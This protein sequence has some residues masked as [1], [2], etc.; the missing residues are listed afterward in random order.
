MNIQV[1]IPQVDY[2][3]M[4]DCTVAI[5]PGT[6]VLHNPNYMFNVSIHVADKCN[7]NCVACG[8]FSPLVPKDTPDMTPA[9]FFESVKYVIPYR[10]HIGC[11]ILTGGEP[12][13]NPHL[14]DII[15]IACASFP[16][17]R[18]VS[19]G[20]NPE[21][22]EQNAEFLL[23]SGI[24]VFVT[25]YNKE[26]SNRIVEAM[27][28][29]VGCYTIPSLEAEGKR[30]MFHSKMLSKERINDLN[31]VGKCGRGECVQLVGTKLYLCQYTSNFEFFD[32]FFKD[33]P[34]PGVE[35]SYIEMTDPSVNLQTIENFI[36]NH[37]CALCW[38]C[39]EPY[40]GRGIPSGMEDVELTH[41]KQEMSEW[42]G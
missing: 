38:H 30:E 25:Q 6:A 16:K 41:S 37:V 40:I 15:R 10:D 33:H 29:K 21:F 31:L 4:N 1:N 11:L 17:V 2:T 34:L 22:F 36:Q 7:K 39:R 23:S 12:T 5:N 13:T 35:D 3:R 18:L 20:L 9:Q 26:L 32:K 19:N 14:L 24:E 42:V 8:H 28:G 27:K